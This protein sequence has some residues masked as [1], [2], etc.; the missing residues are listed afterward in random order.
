MF[1]L[2]NLCITSGEVVYRNTKKYLIW[3]KN[4]I[5]ILKAVK[6]NEDKEIYTTAK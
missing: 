4:G 6:R 2:K 5:E 1:R 3:G